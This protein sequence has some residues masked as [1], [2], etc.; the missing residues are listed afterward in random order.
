MPPI[1]NDEK[2]FGN[3][4]IMDHTDKILGNEE[5]LLTTASGISIDDVVVVIFIYGNELP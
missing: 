4:Y 5:L 3:Q 1:M 2:I